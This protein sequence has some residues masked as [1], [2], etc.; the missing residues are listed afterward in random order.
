MYVSEN[1]IAYKSEIRREYERDAEKYRM[2]HRHQETIHQQVAE[3]QR[4]SSLR[5]ILVIVLNT[6]KMTFR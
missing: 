5:R 4:T 6:M 2:I 1:D 3:T